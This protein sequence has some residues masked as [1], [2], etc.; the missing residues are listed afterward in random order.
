MEVASGEYGE[1]NIEKL[2]QGVRNGLCDKLAVIPNKPSN[3]SPTTMSPY[4]LAESNGKLPPAQGEGVHINCTD[5]GVLNG[6]TVINGNAS[7]GNV[8]G[9]F[10]GLD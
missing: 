8:V 9:V 10:W 2:R 6:H 1:E 5:K 3:G 7:S 4:S